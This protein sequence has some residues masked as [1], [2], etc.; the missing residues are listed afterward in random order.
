MEQKNKKMKNLSKIIILIILS[1]VV[2]FADVNS[3]LIFAAKKGNMKKVAK[4]IKEGANVNTKNSSG[5]TPLSSA[6]FYGHIKVVKYLMS[7]GA[8]IYDKTHSHKVPQNW[9]SF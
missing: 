1:T 4:L 9:A 7:K 5:D 2:A 6:A 3:Q 8:V